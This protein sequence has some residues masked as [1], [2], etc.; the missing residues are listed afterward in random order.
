MLRFRLDK[1]SRVGITVARDG[2]PV[3]ATSAVVGRGLRAYAWRAPARAGDYEVTV[4]ATDLA[5]NQD[6]ATGTLQ[7]LAPKRKH[8]RRG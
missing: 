7:V 2:K 1:I 3:F 8:K 6:R 5:G 4:L